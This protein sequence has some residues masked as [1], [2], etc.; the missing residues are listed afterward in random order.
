MKHTIES[1]G[2]EVNQQ[3]QILNFKDKEISVKE[4]LSIQDKLK[5]ISEVLSNALSEDTEGFYNPVKLEVFAD[6]A[7]VEAYTNIEYS[8]EDREDIS[9][10][11]DKLKSSGLLDLIIEEGIGNPYY[12]ELRIQIENCMKAINSFNNSFYGVIKTIGA[13]R[14]I[15]NF[16]ITE[17]Q[18]KLKDPESLKI[19]KEIAPLLGQNL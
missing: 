2:L 6:V 16:D 1:L 13:N 15:V 5:L 10:L 14:D 11:Y 8:E 18:E 4:Y 7:I 3:E 12:Y 17:L 19:L 9:G